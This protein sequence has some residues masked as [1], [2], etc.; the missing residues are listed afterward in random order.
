[1]ATFDD[2]ASRELEGR[3]LP[4]HRSLIW[5]SGCAYLVLQINERRIALVPEEPVST[6][7]KFGPRST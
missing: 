7:H 5:C 1:M 2:F 3:T 4:E 6:W